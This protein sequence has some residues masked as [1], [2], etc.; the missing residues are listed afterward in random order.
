MRGARFN[1]LNPGF[2]LVIGLIHT[3]VA[4]IAVRAMV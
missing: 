4:W 1:P 3:W 2:R